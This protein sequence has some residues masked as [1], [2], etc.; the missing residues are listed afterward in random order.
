M[1]RILTLYL[2]SFVFL[3]AIILDGKGFSNKRENH[4]I[5]TTLT[6][7]IDNNSSTGVAISSSYNYKAYELGARMIFVSE[8]T[9]F[10]G[11]ASYHDSK[12]E[13]YIGAGTAYLASDN[14]STHYATPMAFYGYKYHLKSFFHVAIEHHILDTVNG[15]ENQLYFGL[16]LRGNMTLLSALWVFSGRNNHY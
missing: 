2:L 8:D 6:A 13:Y 1:K 15:L 4:D 10:L 14:N 16:G 11:F 7:I 5:S 9:K 12:N 3:N